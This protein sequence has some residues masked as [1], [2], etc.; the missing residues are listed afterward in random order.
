MTAVTSEA[1][2]AVDAGARVHM[3]IADQF[4]GARNVCTV[5]RPSTARSGFQNV[6]ETGSQW[7]A[8]L[9]PTT[10]LERS[11]RAPAP[12]AARYRVRDPNSA[13]AMSSDSEEDR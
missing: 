9:S 10:P 1:N 7:V 4:W 2:R 5:S 8:T 13:H 12:P 11:R 6:A 3:P